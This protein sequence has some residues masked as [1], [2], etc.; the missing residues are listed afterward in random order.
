[1]PCHG[2]KGRAVRRDYIFA[3]PSL[4]LISYIVELFTFNV[5]GYIKLKA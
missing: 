1:M 3:A 4:V 2:V 5:G